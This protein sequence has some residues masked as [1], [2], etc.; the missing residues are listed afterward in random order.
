MKTKILNKDMILSRVSQ[1]DI[2]LKA[3]KL[4][5]IPKKNISSPFSEDKKPSF[6]VFNSGDFKCHSTGKVGD[7]F[8]LVAD[9]NNLDCKNQFN[10]VLKLVATDHNLSDDHTNKNPKTPLKTGNNNVIESVATSCNNKVKEDVFKIE[11]ISKIPF[12]ENH[13]RFWE[14]YNVN[15][16]LLQNFDVSAISNYSFKNY[17]FNLKEN[18]I[19]FAYNVN[20]NHEV[21]IPKQKTKEKKFCNG[22][23]A[24]DIFGLKQLPKKVDN[25][26]ICAGK[27]DTLVATAFGFYA[28]TFRSETQTP[29]KEQIATLQS[30]CNN[31]FICYDNDNGGIQGVNRILEKHKIIQLQLPSTVNDIADFFTENTKESFELI[32]QEAL[33]NLSNKV[34]LDNYIFPTEVTNPENYI[35]D[36]EKYKLFVGANR[37]WIAKKSNN[38]T[39]F[40]HITNFAIEILQH[41]QDE[42]LPLKLICMKN[43]VN[44]EVVYD[45]PSD[46]INT[47]PKFIDLISGFGNFQWLGNLKE[48]QLL[49]TYLMDKMK[50]GKK[51]ECLG[52]NEEFNCWIWNNKVQLPNNEEIQI[53]KNGIFEHK[54]NSI[55]VPSANQLYANNNFKYEPQKKFIIKYPKVTIEKYLEKFYIVFKD[56]CIISLLFSLSAIYQDIVVKKI[57]GFPILFLQGIPSTGKDQLTRCCQ[58]FF[59]EPQTAINVEAGVSTVKA[60]IREFAQFT[61]SICQFSE[62]KAGDRQLDGILKGIWDRNGYKRG[63]IESN[64]ATDTVPILSA[65]L[66]T[67]NQTP[68]DEALITRLIWLEMNKDS[69]T[70]EEKKNY[71]ELKELTQN[72]ISSYTNS[73]I[74]YREHYSSNFNAIYQKN[75]TDIDAKFSKLESRFSTNYGILLTT[76]QILSDKITFPFTYDEV[77]NLVIELI[78]KQRSKLSSVGITEKWWNCFTMALQTTTQDNKLVLNKDFKLEGDNLYF[79]F[80]QVFNKIQ[81]VWTN[82]YKTLAPNIKSVQNAI[83]RDNSFQSSVS[84]T[85]IG[86]NN[87]SA[88]LFDINLIS[89]KNEIVNYSN[90]NF[91]NSFPTIP[92]NF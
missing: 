40:E 69:F 55:Y 52:W 14:Q 92:T 37:V 81:R 83:K 76:Y 5:E 20:G 10:D 21:Y 70:E 51:V 71:N 29:T 18:E 8:Q 42:K 39:S 33:N 12:T 50:T 53:D 30:R 6:Q 49:K 28:V 43:T 34:N 59:G 3:L 80:T 4:N 89:I 64:V 25:L 66:L 72:G 54:N 73:L 36:I 87:T 62:Y 90:C 22:L 31:L 86:D 19:A 58:S 23:V 17:S 47:I 67:G 16:E 56:D 27:K 45:T 77:F 7:C 85:R 35:S 74:Q 61:N 26:I 79:N 63:T 88:Y 57:D 44:L 2:T 91:S 82:Q 78:K 32:I 84:S 41:I 46:K 24:T 48:F 11:S 38:K 13:L 68:D 60:H 65:L 1:I 9:L 75:K 15:I